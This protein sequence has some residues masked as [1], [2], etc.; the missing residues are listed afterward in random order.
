MGTRFPHK[1]DSAVS[2]IR[3][4]GLAFRSLSSL[5]VPFFFFGSSRFPHKVT[6]PKKGTLTTIWLLGDQVLETSW[7]LTGDFGFR[8]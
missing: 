3:A 7:V 6:N 1:V 4:S 2:G 5:M 8:V